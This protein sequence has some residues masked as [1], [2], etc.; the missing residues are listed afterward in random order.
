MDRKIPAKDYLVHLD[1]VV[2]DLDLTE[3]INYLYVVISSIF[4]GKFMQ[5]LTWCTGTP[6]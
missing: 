2:N 4:V 1:I 3:V 5:L 6:S